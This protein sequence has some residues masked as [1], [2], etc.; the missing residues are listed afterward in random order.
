M[1][2]PT[3]TKSQRASADYT[4]GTPHARDSISTSA[5]LLGIPADC[6]GRFV[7]FTSCAG[8]GAAV[9]IGIRFGDSN[10]ACVLGDRSALA[11]AT[12]T[13]DVNVPH[14][15]L[16]AGTTRRIRLDPSWTHMSHRGTAATGCLRFAPAEG[17]G[18]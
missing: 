7:E 2:A 14:L 6:I 15:Y 3:A 8:S 12:L 17:A 13:A 5:E 9:D 10:A 18:V 16:V 1:S 4:L 11:T